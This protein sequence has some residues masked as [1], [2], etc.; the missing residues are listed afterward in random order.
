MPRPRFDAARNQWTYYH[1]GKRRYLCTGRA[2]EARAWTLAEKLKGRCLAEAGPEPKTV[3]ETCE[4][5]LRIKHPESEWHRQILKP[6]ADWTVRRSLREVHAEFLT[7]FKIHLGRL[8]Y[9]RHGKLYPYQPSMI[10]RQLRFAR[11]VLQWAHARKYTNDAPPSLPPLPTIKRIDRSIKPDKLAG[12]MAKLPYRA[13]QVLM[14]Q[15]LVGCRPG[16]ACLLRYEEIKG[17]FCELHRG[18]TYERVGEPR[19]LY[20]TREALRLVRDQPT[21]SG[22]VFLNRNGQPYKPSGLRSILKRAAQRAGYH[23][24]GPYCLRHS[25]AQAAVDSG[26]SLDAVG[27]ALG[28]QPGSSET[29]VYAKIS[30]QRALKE[31]QTLGALVPLGLAAEGRPR[32]APAKSSRRGTARPNRHK[33]GKGRS[34]RAG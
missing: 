17:S 21:T 22:Y 4:L 15:A 5:W 10:R 13:K 9:K 3:T 24:P 16:E 26:L 30:R 18:K 8:R 27:E 28:H 14:F 11:S 31:V 7:D 19:L 20:L 33:T 1:H 34:R 12:I 25:W 29:K 23:I 6:F 2:N 32:S